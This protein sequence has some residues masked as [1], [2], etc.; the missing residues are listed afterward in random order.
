MAGAMSTGDF[1]RSVF[2]STV[3]RE[4]AIFKA[5]LAD[6]N[7]AGT[8]ERIFNDIE[9]VRDDYYHAS[10][11]TMHDSK[12]GGVDGRGSSGQLSTTFGFFSVLPRNAY[13]DD[14]VYK[15]C[16][17]AMF[18][19]ER[20]TTWG[21]V[22]DVQRTMG[23]L[24]GGDKAANTYIVTGTGNIEDNLLADPD[25]EVLAGATEGTTKWTAAGVEY[26]TTD[27][28]FEGTASVLL[29]SGGSVKQSVTLEADAHFL[30]LFIKGDV[31]VSITDS[32]GRYWDTSDGVNADTYSNT[33][34]AHKGMGHWTSTPTE[35][36]LHSDEWQDKRIAFIADGGSV[37]IAIKGNSDDA[38]TDWTRLYKASPYPTFSLISVSDMLVSKKAGVTAFM[39][40]GNS[41]YPTN[42]DATNYWIETGREVDGIKEVAHI[43]EGEA[44]GYTDMGK[45]ETLEM[46]Y[47]KMAYIGHTAVLGPNLDVM[48]G[49][50]QMLLELLSPA[51][52]VKH[53]EK[54][55][56]MLDGT[57]I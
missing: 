5:L 26:D 40:P 56:R 13:D 55:A 31:N 9:T 20:R 36:A 3:N 44:M 50:M 57:G 17:R 15:K 27:G 18:E 12:G 10:A 49:T 52:V 4:G 43:G 37:T 41:D 32:T 46:D 11:Y 25:Y 2:P 51:G 23:W 1:I 34:N 29:G 53:F 45:G 19:R 16:M 42:I 21:T 6:D 22:T 35:V 30:H 48:G 8:V 33:N 39:A 47:D 54:L 14:E 7:A 28:R 24:L 38:E